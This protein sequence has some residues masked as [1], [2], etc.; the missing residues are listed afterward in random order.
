MN[1]SDFQSRFYEYVEGSLAPETRLA[2]ESHLA[3]CPACKRMADQEQQTSQTF[4]RH[5]RQETEELTLSPESRKTILALLGKQT[6]PRTGVV[7]W[8]RLAWPMGIAA[9]LILVGALAWPR[10]SPALAAVSVQDP[11]RAR[12]SISG[13]WK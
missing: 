10:H 12:A 13:K 2:A 4:S 5:F 9:C 6:Q 7:W 3:Q 8:N 11:P 1:C